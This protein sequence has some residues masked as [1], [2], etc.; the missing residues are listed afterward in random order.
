[1]S[2]FLIGVRLSSTPS[3]FVLDLGGT[4]FTNL[5]YGTSYQFEL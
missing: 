5:D 3:T 4:K 2:A 1:M